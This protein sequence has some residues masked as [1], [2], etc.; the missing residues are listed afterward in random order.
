MAVK[1]F[2]QETKITL[3]GRNRLKQFVEDLFKVEKKTLVSINYI[4]CSDANLLAINQ[5]FLKHDYYTDVITFNLSNNPAVVEGE[6]YI[7]VDRIRENAQNLGVKLKKELHRVIFHG[8]L[9]LCGYM[10]KTTLEKNK[11]TKA[12]D[13]YLRLYFFESST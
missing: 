10:D 9:H 12:E 5:Q 3:S 6:I 1:F 8:A 4:F 11:M 2:F 13:K 7:S